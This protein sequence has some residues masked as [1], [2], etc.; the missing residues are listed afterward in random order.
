MRNGNGRHRM[1][2]EEARTFPGFSLG[3]AVMVRKI[4]ADTRG[5]KCEPYGD[6]FTLP[7]W[8]AQGF[9]VRKGEHS[10]RIPVWI[11]CEVTERDKV[12]GE[13]RTREVKRPWTARVFCRCQVRPASLKPGENLVP[14]GVHDVPDVQITPPA[15]LAPEVPADILAGASAQA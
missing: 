4:L 7:R 14:L 3:N 12:T 1:T 6:V 2:A 8:N 5:C 9:R 13:E 10:I 15:V 11:P